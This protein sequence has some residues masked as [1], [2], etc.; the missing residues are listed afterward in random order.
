M[1]FSFLN[2]HPNHF[3]ERAKHRA[4]RRNKEKNRENGKKHLATITISAEKNQPT[5]NLMW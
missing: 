5:Y 4:I 3:N 2:V 1:G